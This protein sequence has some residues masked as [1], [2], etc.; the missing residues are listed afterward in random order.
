M[1][2]FPPVPAASSASGLP[3]A[4]PSRP[5]H[6]LKPV[7]VSDAVRR[8]TGPLQSNKFYTNFMLHNQDL[9][10][11]LL[12]YSV[13]WTNGRGPTNCWG[14]T[15]SYATPDQ[16]VFGPTT[17]P[18]GHQG[19]PASYFYSPPIQPSLVLDAAELNHQ[20]A[21]TLD[22]ATDMFVLVS[23]RPGGPAAPPA[24]QF[25]LVQGQGFITALYHGA[26]PIL[27]TGMAIL[28]VW[29]PYNGQGR[30]GGP[31]K[32]GMQ[33]WVLKMNDGS[34]WLVY[35]RARTG[36]PPL[37]F[38]QTADG[39]LEGKG[40][41][42][43]SVHVARVLHPEQ[44]WA[45]YDH[46]A[47]VFAVGV[48]LSGHTE[49]GGAVGQY[50]FAFRK[51]DVTG[52]GAFL[53]NSPLLMFALPHHLA[54]FDERTR[55]AVQ[56]HIAMETPVKG[57][58]RAVLADAWTMVE[59]SLPANMGFLPWDGRTKQAGRSTLSDAARHT[60]AQ[61]ARQELGQDTDAQSNLESAY[62]AGKAL[63]KFA[64]IVLCTHRLLGD[65][66]K[67]AAA[68]GLARLKAA[69]A[70][71]ADNRQKHPLVYEATWGGVV[72]TAA[73]TTGDAMADFG[74][75]YYNDHHFHYGYFV[76]AG[77][78]LA[79]LDP[80]WLQNRANAEYVDLLVRDYANPSRQ[81][82][83]FPVFRSF[84]WYHGHSWASG[85]FPSMDGKNQESS[86][87]DAMAVYAIKMWGHVKGDAAMEQ[88]GNL[89]LS[90]LARS[91]QTYYYYAAAASSSEMPAPF[92]GNQ[93]GG[94]V[95][96]NKI[97]HTTF[98]GGDPELIHGIHMLPLLPCS[99]F[100]RPPAYVLQEWNDT[101]SNGRADKAQG[102]WRGVLYANLGTADPHAAFD[103]FSQ[104]GFADDKLDQGAS[105]TWYL[106]YAAGEYTWL[107]GPFYPIL[108]M[109]CDS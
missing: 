66:V 74:N 44:G 56:P 59:P 30:D 19:P 109:S 18:C 14:L 47:G 71:F 53:A 5:D 26:R 65:E 94:I 102:G 63:A 43:G 62:F 61:V 4:I 33:R 107:T 92:I 80:S 88:R 38:R 1:D 82:A 22:D 40:G 58:A 50:S 52:D 11:Y 91:L 57:T 83:Q 84:D 95:F 105:R 31:L 37:A 13:S 20:T 48:H 55:A 34:T 8:S 15:V 12:P 70:R 106:C 108:S 23:L 99:P 68:D 24:V 7:G 60:I 85:V 35:A 77:A 39:A 101:F 25:P 76:F 28:S 98:F 73:Y 64:L 16:R 69:F 86:S 41:F 67:D 42:H 54:S 97:D 49:N 78:V 3:A 46:A 6:P 2:L 51:V 89:M 36:A 81:D 10:T 93:V 72:S 29:D 87:E 90:V 96:E 104:P 103:Y 32:P 45:A 21:L 100:C 79:H 17:G 27:R 9:P 75:S